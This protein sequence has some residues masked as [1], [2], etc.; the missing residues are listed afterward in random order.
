MAGTVQISGLG[1]GLDTSKI[2]EQ[3]MAVE[4][5]PLK[6]LESQQRKIM[7][8]RPVRASP[9]TSSSESVESTARSPSMTK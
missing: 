3:L 2:I 7:A 5:R 4:Q 1:S 9:T 8:S 6:Q